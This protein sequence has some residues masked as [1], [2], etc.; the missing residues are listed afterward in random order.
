[1]IT[2][3]TFIFDGLY[4]KTLGDITF[5]KDKENLPLIVFLH[6]FKGFKDW[7][8]FNHAADYFASQG[9]AFAKFNFFYNGT[10]LEKPVD[11][12][13]LNRFSKNTYLKE[14]EEAHHFINHAPSL[15]EEKYNFKSEN[16]YLI[17]HSRGGGIAVLT[18]A[19]NEK[20]DKLVTWS[21]VADFFTRFPLD[22]NQEEWKKDEYVYVANK[23]TGQEL[24]MHFN[25]YEE[26]MR[27]KE[28][29][30]I[31]T[32]AQSMDTPYLIIHGG[33][34]EAVD[35]NNAEKLKSATPNSELHIEPHAGHTFRVSHPFEEE[36]LPD[37]FQNVLEKTLSFLKK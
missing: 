27:N 21:S 20:V 19:Q 23:R 15:L 32:H 24:P 14:L 25:F 4:G 26:A 2:K 3:A 37:N 31:L 13:D 16:I 9:F 35:I 1:M 5:P 36:T 28:K 11:F 17:G 18:A 7:G 8:A 12:A 30:D 34:D 10:T 29:L 6:G 22:L 33:S